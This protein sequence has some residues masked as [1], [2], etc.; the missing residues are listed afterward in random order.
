[1][2]DIPEVGGTRLARRSGMAENAELC[3]RRARIASPS[4]LWPAFAGD[5]RSAG[6]KRQVAGSFG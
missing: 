6:Q 3:G 2:V 5:L 1:M 4:R